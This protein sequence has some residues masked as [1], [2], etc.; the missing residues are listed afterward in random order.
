[1]S[2]IACLMRWYTSRCFFYYFNLLQSRNPPFF[3]GV[4][5]RD[6]GAANVCMAHSLMKCIL[7]LINSCASIHFSRGKVVISYSS[8]VS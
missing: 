3:C 8:Y 5:T 7:R 2:L 6:W 1:M 4:S